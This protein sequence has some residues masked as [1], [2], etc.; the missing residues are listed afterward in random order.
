MRKV[1]LFIFGSIVILTVFCF[2]LFNYVIYPTKDEE[3]VLHYAKEY[4]LDEALVFAIIKNESNFN[5]YA[6][7]TSG[8]LGLM[9]IMPRTGQWIASELGVEYYSNILYD[10][11]TNIRFGCFYLN[12]L[13]SKF[14]NLDIVICAYNAGEVAVKKW[15]DSDGNLDVSKIDYT[16]TYNYYTHVIRDYYFYKTQENV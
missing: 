7:S 5:P 4:N 2:I 3:F 11:E 13:Y 15:L 16:E 6:K 1:I 9:Q 12:Y 14:N 8:A 10:E